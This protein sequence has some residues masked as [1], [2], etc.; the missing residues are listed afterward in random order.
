MRGNRA[1]QGAALDTYLKARYPNNTPITRF[2]PGVTTMHSIPDSQTTRRGFLKAGAA[3]TIGLV[4]LP[5]LLQA[6]DKD[7]TFGGFTLGVQSYSFRNFDTEQA[8][9]RTQDLGL[10]VVEFYQKHAPLN[11]SPE[12]IKALLKLCS[13]YGIKP[14]AYGVQ[15]FTKDH[16]AN[17]KHFEFGKEL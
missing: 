7:Q 5:A 17:K 3:A 15:H 9:K 2:S 14:V 10:H 1:G 8:L 6:E 13:E 4:G 12:Q 11:S 16:D